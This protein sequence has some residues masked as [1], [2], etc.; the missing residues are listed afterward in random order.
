M[1]ENINLKVKERK[2]QWKKKKNNMSV[3]KEGKINENYS[4]TFSWG[5]EQNNIA[6]N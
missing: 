4:A 1:C 2:I 6:K 5:I 3:K